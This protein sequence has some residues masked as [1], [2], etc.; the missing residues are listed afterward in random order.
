MVNIFFVKYLNLK[1]L[2]FLGKFYYVD[3]GHI[4]KR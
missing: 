4:V 2:K 3:R 1:L